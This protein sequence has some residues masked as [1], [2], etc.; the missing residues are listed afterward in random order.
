MEIIVDNTIWMTLNT[1]LAIFAVACGWMV[2]KAK[3]KIVKLISGILW[4]LFLPNTI[5]ILTDIIH[6]IMQFEDSAGNMTIIALSLQYL[7]LISIG[8]LSFV[9]GIYPL[10]ILLKSKRFKA[11]EIYLFIIMFN[12]VIIF[13]VFL[14]RIHRLNSWDVITDAAKVIESIK[15][16]IQ[17]FELM[18]SVITFG[19]IASFVYFFLRKTA[20]RLVSRVSGIFS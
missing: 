13:G 7:M 10:E 19:L 16:T 5:Y 4:I 17:S 1:A 20:V 8:L 11:T 3:S 6:L 14:G 9:Y 18:I 15:H 12:F 2:I